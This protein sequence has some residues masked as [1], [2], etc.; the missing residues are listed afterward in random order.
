[1][2]L[3]LILYKFFLAWE[4][5][6]TY[7]VPTNKDKTEDQTREGKFKSLIVYSCFLGRNGTVNIFVYLNE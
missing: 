2:L 3:S 5:E 4:R 6:F 7:I 1:M